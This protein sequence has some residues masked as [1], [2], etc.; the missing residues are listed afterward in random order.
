MQRRETA[1]INVARWAG[2]FGVQNENFSEP[3][4][5][6]GRLAIKLLRKREKEH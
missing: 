1:N 2:G 4:Y 3:E 5:R 6:L